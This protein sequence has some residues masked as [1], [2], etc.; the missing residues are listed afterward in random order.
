MLD[1][2][3][4]FMYSQQAWIARLTLMNVNRI[5]ALT[6]PV[7]WMGLTTT[8]APACPDSRAETAK[9]TSTNVNPSLVSMAERVL[10]ASTSTPA[11]A[12]TPAS[13]GFTASSTSTNALHSRA[14][15]MELA[16]MGSMITT[17]LVMTDTPAKTANW[18]W[19]NAQIHLVKMGPFA[20]NGA[21]SVYMAWRGKLCWPCLS[22]SGPFSVARSATTKPQDTFAVVCPVMKVR[23][24]AKQWI[25]LTLFGDRITR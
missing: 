10:M 13:R 16:P 14:L 7:A 2:V 23:K 4:Y 22:M 18:T 12:M 8:L 6:G 17:V 19:P 11:T 20:S 3:I 1:I 25:N 21:T 5:H 9:P 24:H 15:I